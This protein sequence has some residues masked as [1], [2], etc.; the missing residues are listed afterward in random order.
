MNYIIENNINFFDELKKE[1]SIENN[2]HLDTN[3]NICLIS[4][5]ILKDNFITLSC[6]HKFNYLPL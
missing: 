4:N 1:L 3:D 6:N 5:E 2:K